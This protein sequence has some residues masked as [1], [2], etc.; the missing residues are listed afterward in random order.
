MAF[1]TLGSSVFDREDLAGH[2]ME[3]N[4]RGGF[5][6][7]LVAPALIVDKASG[8]LM[9]VSATTGKTLENTKRGRGGAYPE[10]SGSLSDSSYS[11][12]DHG[13]NF[14]V[15]STQAAAYR[16]QIDMDK[17]GSEASFSTVATRYEY[18]TFAGSA[19]VYTLVSGNGA[20][21]AWTT[22]ATATP[23]ADVAVEAAEITKLHGVAKSEMSLVIPR[24]RFDILPFVA[25]VRARLQ[26]TSQP[27]AGSLTEAQLAQYFGVK[28]VIVAGAVYNTANEAQTAS[29]SYIHPSNTCLL[30]VRSEGNPANFAGFARTPVWDDTMP[31]ETIVERIEAGGIPVI[32]DQIWD[33]DNRIMKYRARNYRGLWVHMATMGRKVTGI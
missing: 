6:A 4:N 3:V 12:E 17:A 11:T 2:I 16:N 18:D 10:V 1:A 14:T 22:Y 8:T 7:G 28:E 30:F 26:I 20:A 13:A 25:D 33:P 27:F 5:V 21:A 9:V 15:E 29:M 31:Y 32:I 24:A 23:A 19:S